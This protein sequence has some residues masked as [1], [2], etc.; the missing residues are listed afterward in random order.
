MNVRWRLTATLLV[1]AVVTSACAPATT[2]APSAP[3]APAAATFTPAPAVATPAPAP[4]RAVPVI[5]NLQDTEIDAVLDKM[6]ATADPSEQKKLALQVY[7]RELDQAYRPAFP[8][9]YSY[10][11]H[12]GKI[13]NYRIVPRTYIVETYNV[14]YAWRAAE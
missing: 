4:T 13:K 11:V 3:I 10:M 6:R 5:I 14:R 1:V 8:G 12:S 9:S 2:P 7:Q